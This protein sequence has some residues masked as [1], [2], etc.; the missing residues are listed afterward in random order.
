MILLTGKRIGTSYSVQW[1]VGDPPAARRAISEDGNT[2]QTQ[3]SARQSL[4]AG[5]K[6]R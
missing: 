1:Q 5:R 4:H 3:W 6:S 2:K